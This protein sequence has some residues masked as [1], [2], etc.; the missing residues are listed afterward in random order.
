MLGEEISIEV[1]IH[2]YCSEQ[3]NSHDSH[4]KVQLEVTIE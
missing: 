3:F 1:P 2:K 4:E